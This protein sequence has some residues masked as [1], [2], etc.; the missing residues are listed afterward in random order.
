MKGN[1]LCFSDALSREVL[2][3]TKNTTCLNENI[4]KNA[5]CIKPKDFFMHKYYNFHYLKKLQRLQ[6]VLFFI[7]FVL[8]KFSI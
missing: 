2:L 6:S 4:I 5:V 7:S 8:N 1:D 3:I